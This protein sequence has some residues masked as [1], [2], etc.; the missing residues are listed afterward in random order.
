MKPVECTLVLKEL[1]LLLQIVIIK[2]IQVCDNLS[3]RLHQIRLTQVSDYVTSQ[4]GLR[5]K[6]KILTKQNHWINADGH[7]FLR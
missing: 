6:H 2:I 5:A 3:Y 4:P 1:E 7:K